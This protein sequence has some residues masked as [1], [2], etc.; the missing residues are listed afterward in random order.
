MSSGSPTKTPAG[1]FFQKHLPLFL[2]YLSAEK[3]LSSNTLEAY[4]RDLAAF[5][6]HLASSRTDPSRLTRGDVVAYLGVRRAEG[7]SPRTLARITSSL[8]GLYG[9]LAAEKVVEA[10]PTADLTNARRWAMLP[11]VLSPDDVTRL[12]D[13]P[14]VTTPKGLRNRA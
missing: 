1:V 2:D 4:R 6:T 9:F 12:L 8:R 11:K 13:A 14:D 10:D 5:G 3:G 7:M